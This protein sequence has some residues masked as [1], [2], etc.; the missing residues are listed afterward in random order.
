MRHSE[1]RAE[2]RFGLA[3]VWDV[4]EPEVKKALRKTLFRYR[5]HQDQELFDR[6][7]GYV[8]EYY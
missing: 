4:G 5:L 7:H 8:R 2:C 1:P 6:A 3:D